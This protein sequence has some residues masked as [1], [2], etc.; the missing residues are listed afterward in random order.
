MFRKEI[1]LGREC[2]VFQMW[3]QASR[4]FMQTS[5]FLYQALG[6]VPDK[7]NQVLSNQTDCSKVFLQTLIVG[8]SEKNVYGLISDC[9]RIPVAR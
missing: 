3:I 7:E 5:C 2:K 8:V 1:A 4:Y 6:H 9:L